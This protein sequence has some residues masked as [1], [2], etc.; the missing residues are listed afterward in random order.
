M[1]DIVALF[2]AIMDVFLTSLSV[3]APFICL[4]YLIFKRSKSKFVISIV[5]MLAVT[6]LIAHI[7][8]IE[9]TAHIKEAAIILTS[10]IIT[11]NSTHS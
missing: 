8:G 1:S 5:A 9:D 2:S 10:L 6:N 3:V 7:T 11:I 4:V